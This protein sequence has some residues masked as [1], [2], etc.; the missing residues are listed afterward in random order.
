MPKS[1][2]FTPSPVPLSSQS[3]DKGCALIQLQDVTKIFRPRR[4][5]I[6]L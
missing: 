1:S 2:S 3:V 5:N 6:L 4:V